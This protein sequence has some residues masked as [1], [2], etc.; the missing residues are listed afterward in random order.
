MK[1]D[2]FAPLGSPDEETAQRLA[3][4]FS[5]A[6]NDK[7]RL[8]AM[9][10]RKM[11]AMKIDDKKGVS[12]N[13]EEIDIKNTPKWHAPLRAAAGFAAAAAV[14]IVVFGAVRGAE[15]KIADM[16]EDEQI[17]DRKE[18]TE[19]AAE[20]NGVYAAGAV[21]SAYTGSDERAENSSTSENR[22]GVSSAAAPQKKQADSS[23]SAEKKS[24]SS[25]EAE[26]SVQSEA[27][28]PKQ[29]ID[30]SQENNASS[31]TAEEPASSAA[32]DTESELPDESSPSSEPEYYD[33][34]EYNMGNSGEARV[35]SITREMTYR[36][37]IDRL[38]APQDCMIL[39][40]YAQ[41]VIDGEWLLM[42]HYDDEN[43]QI[44][45]DGQELLDSCPRLSEMINDRAS[46]T[47]DCY[48]IDIRGEAIRVTCPQYDGFDCT[49]PHFTDEQREYLKNENV[50]VGDKLRITHDDYVL[51]IYPCICYAQSVEVIR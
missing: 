45:V 3:A 21:S 19:A 23:Q 9:S 30:S 4:H 18:T 34:E 16:P 32:D 47:F 49:D 17:I 26:K 40:G 6:E 50:K 5:L 28:A 8:F 29:I 51:T 44:G 38:G 43:E 15:P 48:V 24:V 20:D 11:K 10:E 42:L 25:S 41:Y 39:N 35:L 33:G 46:L 14:V 13:Y 7:D 22:S 31:V 36:Q 27:S 2:I 37:V 1:K 12:P